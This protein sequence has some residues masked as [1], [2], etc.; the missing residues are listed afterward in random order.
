MISPADNPGVSAMHL[1]QL[2][3]FSNRGK[4]SPHE[5]SPG[6]TGD[7]TQEFKKECGEKQLFQQE[8]EWNM[9]TNV[10]KVYRVSK[11]WRV[12]KQQIQAARAVGR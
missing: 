6:P 7:L 2:E 4:E 9:N 8:S 11:T 10:K 12:S 3:P 5:I 1:E